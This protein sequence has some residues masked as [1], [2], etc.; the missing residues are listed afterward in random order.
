M[1]GSSQAF[2]ELKHSHL[3]MLEEDLLPA[4]DFLEFFEAA[5][6]VL[7]SDPS[8]WCASAFNDFGMKSTAS[9]RNRLLRTD[10]FPG[11][12]WMLKREL[13]TSELRK[14][15]PDF[16]STGWDHWFR[17]SSTSKGRECIYPEVPRTVH[18]GIE[19]ANVHESQGNAMEDRYAFAKERGSGFTAAAD[20]VSDAYD[21]WL[22]RTVEGA[23]R[24]SLSGLSRVQGGK[25]YVV[26]YVTEEFRSIKSAFNL[27]P[28]NP[29]STHKG[30]IW[31]RGPNDAVVLV[32]D[33]RVSEMLK[34]SEQLRPHP[35]AKILT[36]HTAESCDARC[37]REAGMRCRSACCE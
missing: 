18:I 16:P 5:A 36:A 3:I 35:R 7:D 13:W 8:V 12:G 23:Q 6:P 2:V 34:Q 21:S 17:L 10:Y 32:I 14:K 24:I 15:W 26:P 37:S 4:P 27:W 20:L 11:L 33:R 28:D 29:R 1:R 31:L 25:V 19:G 22:R 9:D 30:V